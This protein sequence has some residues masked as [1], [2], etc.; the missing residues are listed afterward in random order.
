VQLH[1]I[2]TETLLVLL[3][4]AARVFP[5]VAF[6]AGPEQGLLVASSG[7]LECD[8]A[9]LKQFDEEPAVRNELAKLNLPGLEAL[10]GELLLVDDSYRRATGELPRFG[11]PR[12]QISSDFHP[13]LEYATPK[14]NALPYDTAPI[15]LEFLSRHRPAVLPTGL[16]N[17]HN[18]QS[19]AQPAPDRIR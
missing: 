6:F 13:I 7:P 8:F 4:T 3:N 1:H 16:V 2:R 12:G 18:G 5:H 19:A 14:G 10:L 11:Y 15:N 17:D 9:R